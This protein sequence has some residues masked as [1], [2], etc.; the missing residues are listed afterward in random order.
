MRPELTNWGSNPLAFQLNCFCNN[1]LEAKTDDAIITRNQRIITMFS[2]TFHPYFP[3]ILFASLSACV[4]T[5]Q[6]YKQKYS[7]Y[8]VININ[9]QWLYDIPCI[10]GTQVNYFYYDK[11]MPFNFWTN[12]N[13][14]LNSSHWMTIL[15]ISV[16]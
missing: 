15:S 6:A 13:A 1:H 11:C 2:S 7:R 3:C 10:V 16:K 9:V 14:I 8:R 5:I 12:K 4:P